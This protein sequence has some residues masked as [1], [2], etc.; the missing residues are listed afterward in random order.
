MQSCATCVYGNVDRCEW[1]WR[2]EER[3]DAGW[4]AIIDSAMPDWAE[5]AI[6]NASGRR[7][8]D[9]DCKGC[10]AFDEREEKEKPEGERCPNTPDMFARPLSQ[11]TDKE[12]T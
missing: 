1:P 7:V 5:R 10:S 6:E 2:P 11:R 12:T 4:D 3:T 9:L 8:S